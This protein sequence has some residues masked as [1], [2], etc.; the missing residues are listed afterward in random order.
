M[1][2]GYTAP[3]IASAAVVMVMKLANIVMYHIFNDI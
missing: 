3:A 1:V 2:A